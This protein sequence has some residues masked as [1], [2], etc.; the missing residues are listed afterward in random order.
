MQVLEFAH[1]P[2][3]CCQTFLAEFRSPPPII[4]CMC[5]YVCVCTYI[6]T[7]IHTYVYTYIR[8]YIHTYG[9]LCCFIISH[10]NV[11]ENKEQI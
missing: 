7:Y 1:P 6:H 5:M 8:I 2:P 4:D 3:G 10:V 11:T 9:M